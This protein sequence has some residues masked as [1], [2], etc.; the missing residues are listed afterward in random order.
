MGILK[1]VDKIRVFNEIKYILNSNCV[2]CSLEMLRK[3]RLL[4]SFDKRIIIDTRI[5]EYVTTL[6]NMVNSYST[7]WK[8]KKIDKSIA[9]LM[10]LEYLLRKSLSFCDTIGADEK[11]SKIVKKD[12]YQF[13]ECCVCTP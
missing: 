4:Y 3:Y 11:T 7:V 13:P 10:L 1:Y 6:E 8:D 12:V 2:R 9:F 5:L